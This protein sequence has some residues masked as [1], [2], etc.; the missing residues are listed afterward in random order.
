CHPEETHNKINELIF[1]LMKGKKVEKI[2]NDKNRKLKFVY[3]PIFDDNNNNY[4]G[5]IEL[6]DEI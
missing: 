2:I 5:F 4:R 6:S 1:S 3:Y